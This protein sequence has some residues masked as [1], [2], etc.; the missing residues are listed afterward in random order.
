MLQNS[1]YVDLSRSCNIFDFYFELIYSLCMA[2]VH[3]NELVNKE[4]LACGG[5][6]LKLFVWVVVH[7][8]LS[9][10]KRDFV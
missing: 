2:V 8:N 4:M 5:C 7:L 10:K 6:S 1:G 9:G 3:D